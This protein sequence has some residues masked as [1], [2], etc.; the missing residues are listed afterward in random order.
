L[1]IT[2]KA[3]FQPSQHSEEARSKERT[4]LGICGT[5]TKQ[6]RVMVSRTKERKQI[7]ILEGV[8][9]WLKHSQICSKDFFVKR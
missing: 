1:G 6:R 8:F 2:L 3:I 7:E 5:Q 4:V 9:L